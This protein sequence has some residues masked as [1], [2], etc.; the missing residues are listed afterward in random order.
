MKKYIYV[1]LCC[2]VFISFINNVEANSC[3]S[4]KDYNF[5]ATATSGTNVTIG[6]SVVVKVNVTG[7]AGYFSVT[8]SNNSILSGGTSR[9]WIDNGSPTFNFQTKSVGTATIT[10]KGVASPYCS[11]V[12][13]NFEQ[14]ITITVKP[15]PVIVLSG[16]NALA[17][18]GVDGKELSPA[19][20]RDTLEYSVELE[21]D[22][23]S[24]NVSASPSHGGASISGAGTREV[25]DGENR[26]EIVVTAENG[27]T[28]TYVLNASVKEYNPIKQKVDGKEYTVVRK[29]SL[30]KGP[31]NYTETTTMINGEEV[32]AFTSE[33]TKYTLV[34]LRN[35]SGNINL[36]VYKDGNYTL[37]NEYNFNKVILYPIEIPSDKIPSGYEKSKII[38]NDDELVAYKMN[39]L[40]HFAILYGM[41]VETGE[42][43]I[44]MYD[45]EEDTIQ[46]YNDEK[47]KVLEDE[48]E[49][50]KLIVAGL[51]GV[52][53]FLLLLC[54]II[55]CSK[56]GKEKNINEI[57]NMD[58]IKVTE[59]KST[60]LSKRE[61]KKLIQAEQLRKKEE[62][63]IN[64]KE[65]KLKAREDA[66]KLK[67]EL[68]LAKKE[69]RKKK[70]KEEPIDIRNI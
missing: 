45:E 52:S 2:F 46:I 22:T 37:Y 67:E 14:K 13:K 28:R 62:E 23:T 25:V 30:L 57:D 4:G 24:I 70:E 6:A 44:Y 15:K 69:K 58:D 1:I 63:K 11:G 48:L 65:A 60:E 34:G 26:L 21:P 47:I 59:I 43:H 20:N 16:D 31:E 9:V 53:A 38:Y 18:L 36:Y 39:E 12:D 41:N 51:S 56:K 64:K 8:S 40:S 5:Y 10:I 33:V 55:S 27:A 29:K 54:I 42:E 66:K 32:P 35:E 17:S 61:E 50:M 3:D 7:M 49:K 68:R 19:F